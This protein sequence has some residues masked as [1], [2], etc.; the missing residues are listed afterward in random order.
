MIR[1]AARIIGG[2][3]HVVDEL[4]RGGTGVVHRCVD[5]ELGRFAAVKVFSLFEGDGAE[6]D[7]ARRRFV[8]EAR[9][10][11][12]SR[13]PQ[14]VEIFDS[15][16]TPEGA[17]YIAT[18]LLSGPVLS[19]RGPMGWRDVVE[20]GVQVAQAL[21]ALHGRGIIHRDI[22]PANIVAVGPAATGPLFIK[23]ID[24]G[25]AKV[26]AWALVNPELT[27][28]FRARETRLGEILGTPGYVAPEAGLGPAD[29]QLDVFGLGVTLYQLCTGVSP[30]QGP[31]RPLRELVP[32]AP[33]ALEELLSAMLSAD[34]DERPKTAQIVLDRLLAVLA[35]ASE[36][37]TPAQGQRIFAQT[38]ELIDVLGSGARS[39]VIRGYDRVAQR[40]VAIKVLKDELRGD[41]EERR[42]FAVEAMLLGRLDDPAIPRIYGGT[43]DT[44]GDDDP[45]FLVM[46]VAAGEPASRVGFGREPL[47]VSEVIEA[48]KQLA[49]ALVKIH[50]IGALHRDINPSNVLVERGPKLRASLIDLGMAELTPRFYAV[51]RRYMTPPERRAACPR[52]LKI[53]KNL[54]WTAPEVRLGAPWSPLCDVFSLAFV[55]FRLA[56]G[57]VPWR[58]GSAQVAS[59]EAWMPGCP[60]GLKEAFAGALALNPAQRLDAAGLLDALE[61]AEE[62]LR[63]EQIVQMEKARAAELT[64]VGAEDP[65]T[66]E[67]VRPSPPLP[68]PRAPRWRRVVEGIA[69]AAAL[70]AIG[71]W[72]RGL[73]A[74]PKVAPAGIAASAGASTTMVEEQPPIAAVMRRPEHDVAPPIAAVLTTPAPELPT[75]REALE[76]SEAAFVGCAGL[77]EDPLLVRFVTVDGSESFASVSIIG[78]PTA[79]VEGCVAALASSIRFTPTVALS[80]IEEYLP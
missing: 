29:P 30:G 15:G 7:E 64:T 18:E 28:R 6:L 52:D 66:Q 40:E 48:G 5:L 50:E 80:L 25:I 70:I 51:D 44:A 4:G 41:A 23:I 43:I 58:T 9:L 19:G 16:L 34:L 37:G 54:E 59:L 8:D 17:P 32:G 63:E 20:I 35:A 31:M 21:V 11:A 62:E 77:A 76:R 2:R 75:M 22:K 13:H 33:E 67:F 49:R 57:K 55:L 1:D 36:A 79:E 42:R 26:L 56:T 68:A 78:A 74:P 45:V 65:P 3:F 73:A 47:G 27:T 53:L 69:S 61:L 38:F 60:E 12:S 39:T 46:S 71:W 24:L 10:L 14:I 72:S